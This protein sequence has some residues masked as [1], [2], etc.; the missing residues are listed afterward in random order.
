MVDT[1]PSSLG[2]KSDLLKARKYYFSSNLSLSYASDEP[3]WIKRGAGQYLYDDQDQ[4]YLDC[5]N[6]V[7]HI[8]HSHPAITQAAAAQLSCLNTNTRYLQVPLLEYARELTSTLPDPLQVC[9]FVCSG[10][11]AND[12]ALRLA[13]EYTQE[14]DVM[15]L[16]VAYHGHLSSMIDISPYKYNGKGGAHEPKEHVHPIDAPDTFRGKYRSQDCAGKQYAEQVKDTL[17]E[18]ERQNKGIAA[19]YAESVM[20]SGIHRK[21]G[22]MFHPLVLLNIGLCRANCFT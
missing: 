11:E 2:D 3:L 10:S 15:V 5:V 17:K 20:V 13:R 18:L 14:Q 6:N 8:G 21:A 19:F 16:D 7:A 1:P 4:Q 9:F 22:G 12:L